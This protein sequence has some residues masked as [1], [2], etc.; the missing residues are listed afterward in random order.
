MHPPVPGHLWCGLVSHPLAQPLE[1]PGT[2]LET[3]ETPGETPQPPPSQELLRK[4][5]ALLGKAIHG[6]ELL[7]FACSVSGV[8]VTAA[9]HQAQSVPVNTNLY[10][11][12]RG[13]AQR[14][15][16]RAE[17]PA[18]PGHLRNFFSL[19]FLYKIIDLPLGRANDPLLKKY[20]SLA[21]L[22]ETPLSL[23]QTLEGL[24]E[25]TQR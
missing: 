11:G 20:Y 5:K 22:P 12:G 24:F 13:G 14:R 18:G 2:P 16:L 19:S 23:S 7:N 21:F 15:L 1:P 6:L 8:V 25:L 10:P 3:G 17:Q 9:T 4:Q